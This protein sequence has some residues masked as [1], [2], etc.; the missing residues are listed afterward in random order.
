MRMR[1]RRLVALRVGQEELHDV[2][3]GGGGRAERVVVPDVGSD[4]H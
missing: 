3:L 2:G 1:F 4:L